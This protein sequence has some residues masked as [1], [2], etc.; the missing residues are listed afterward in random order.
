[1]DF[2]KIKEFVLEKKLYFIVAVVLLVGGLWL[3]KGDGAEDS[4]DNLAAP[5]PA[6]QLKSIRQAVHQIPL[7]LILKQ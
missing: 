3:K 1:M 6:H 7:Q 2:E 4:Y 5:I